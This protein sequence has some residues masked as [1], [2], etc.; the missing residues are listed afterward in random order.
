MLKHYSRVKGEASGLGEWYTSQ[1]MVGTVDF[2]GFIVF[3]VGRVV[4]K[5]RNNCI[6]MK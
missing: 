2:A 5:N 1:I 3:E 6:Q 4:T